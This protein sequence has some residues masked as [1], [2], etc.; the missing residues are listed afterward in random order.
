MVIP[1]SG[2]PAEKLPPIEPDT[3][4]EVRPI[5]R[6]RH[7]DAMAWA[8]REAEKQPIPAPDF[9]LHSARNKWLWRFRTSLLPI[10]STVDKGTICFPLSEPVPQSQWEALRN[11]ARKKP[12]DA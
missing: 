5:F 3:L 1:H 2:P 6:I 12:Q 10:R 9:V 4:S 11:S 8:N 7:K